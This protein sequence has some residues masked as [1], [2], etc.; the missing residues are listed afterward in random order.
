[1][2]FLAE[3]VSDIYGLE[4]LFAGDAPQHLGLT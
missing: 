2:L 1:M 4:I 3:T